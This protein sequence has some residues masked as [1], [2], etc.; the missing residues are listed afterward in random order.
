MSGEV[1]SSPNPHAVEAGQNAR[2][3]YS[4]PKCKRP[5]ERLFD[6]DDLVSS[7][8]VFRFRDG[9]SAVTYR[10]SGL[11]QACQDAVFQQER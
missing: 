7:M 10:Q 5:P 4:C 2:G 6:G 3:F 8:A 11:C 1:S 9:P